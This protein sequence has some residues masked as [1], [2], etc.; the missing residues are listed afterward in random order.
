VVRLKDLQRASR[1][2]EVIPIDEEAGIYLV[3]SASQ[4]GQ[5]Y[6][7]TIDA[8][9]LAGQCSCPWAQH[10]GI[11]CKHVLAVLRMHYAET[12][13]LSF[14]PSRQEA[15][16]QHRQIIDGEQLFATLRHAA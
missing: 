4:P 12:G 16:R 10:G 2:L 1:R 13:A 15:S 7:V 11:N 8:E 14:W 3:S 5:H 6:R 9:T